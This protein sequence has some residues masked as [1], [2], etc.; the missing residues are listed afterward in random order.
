MVASK[1]IAS[2]AIAG[3]CLLGARPVLA[4]DYDAPYHDLAPELQF[5]VDMAYLLL[6]GNVTKGR[7]PTVLTEGHIFPEGK[8]PLQAESENKRT[9]PPFKAFDQLTYLGMNTVG[10][11]AVKTSAG[12]ILIDTLDNTEEAQRII[13]GGMKAS[14]LN[15]ADIKYIIITHAHGDHFGGAKYLQDKYHAH[16]MMSPADWAVMERGAAQPPR[17]GRQPLP[18]PAHDMD[19]TD[20]QK[21]TLGNMTMTIYITPGHTP[22]SL[23]FI[24]PVTDHGK[25]HVVAFWGGTGFP[26]S[27]DP[28]PTN[29]GLQAYQDQ[30]FR[31]AK[32]CTDAKCD[33]IIANHP[34]ADGTVEKSEIMVKRKASDPNP[35]VVGN[36]MV[37]RY[38]GSTLA[39][40]HASIIYRET[41][42]QAASGRGATTN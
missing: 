13:E 35:Y 8:T 33:A 5:N 41:H 9:L 7:L 4:A 17:A 36:D 19:I 31:Y 21:F 2:I 18:V 10:S 34:V 12:I 28:T 14:G 39:A 16:V 38:Y 3:A 30:I 27:I 42:P 22:G 37:T 1:F 11:W 23:S 40:L 24:I 26:Q 15:P 32:A 25:K 29:G 20:G 6:G